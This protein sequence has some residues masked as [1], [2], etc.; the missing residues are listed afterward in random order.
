M[1]NST[2]DELTHFFHSCLKHHLMHQLNFSAL[3]TISNGLYIVM[4]LIFSTLIGGA[5]FNWNGYAKVSQL[6]M[7]KCKF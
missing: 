4:E 3:S 1:W 5:S 6:A 7:E 2:L